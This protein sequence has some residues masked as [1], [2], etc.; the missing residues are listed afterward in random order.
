MQRLRCRSKLA[1]RAVGGPTGGKMRFAYSIMAIKIKPLGQQITQHTAGIVQS[2]DKKNAKN[3]TFNKCLETYPVDR[4]FSYHSSVV[5]EI[6]NE[7]D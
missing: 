7:K 2:P 4:G 6:P 1:A 3:W 5:C